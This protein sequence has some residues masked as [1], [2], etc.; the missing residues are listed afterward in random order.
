MAIKYPSIS[1][2][3]FPLA[4]E[5]LPAF[6]AAYI[7]LVLVFAGLAN[8]GFFAVLIVLHVLLDFIKYRFVL[9]F[10]FLRAYFGMLRESLMD[11]TLFFLALS[12]YVYLNP[13]LPTI[14]ILSDVTQWHVT[15][16]RGLALLLPKLTILHHLLRVVFNLPTYMRSPHPR[17]REPFT[18]LD[19]ICI[20]TFLIALVLL[21]L[22]PHLLSLDAEQF[23][24]MLADELTP[25][26]F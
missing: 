12:T 3:R 8:L 6:H 7:M 1:L 24:S 15:V 9:V 23:R 5:D 21:V 16:M 20:F 22:A 25:W 2:R 17:L 10:K 14:Q 18:L 11:I 26:K 4:Y 13:A 19:F